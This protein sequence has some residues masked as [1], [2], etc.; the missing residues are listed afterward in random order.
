MYSS[1]CFEQVCSSVTNATTSSDCYSL[2]SECEYVGGPV[3][4]TR[5]ASCYDYILDPSVTDIDAKLAI[6]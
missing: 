1:S 2:D 6:C 3:C 4:V 5:K